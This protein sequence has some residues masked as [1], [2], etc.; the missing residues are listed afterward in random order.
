VPFIPVSALCGENLAEKSDKFLWYE[1]PTLL[2]A[3]QSINPLKRLTEKPLRFC[4]Q[5]VRRIGNADTTVLFGKVE[6]GI[7]RSGMDI[8]INP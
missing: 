4:V 3:L 1:G 6:T 2:Q 7:L 5:N 8:V